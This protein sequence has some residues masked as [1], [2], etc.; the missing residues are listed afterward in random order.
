VGLENITDQRDEQAEH[1]GGAERDAD[2]A[3]VHA[4]AEITGQLAKTK[5]AQEGGEPADQEEG[6][7]GDEKPTHELG[8]LNTMKIIAASARIHWSRGQFGLKK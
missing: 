4:E 7:E 5:A 2:V 3:P 1:D 6:E 8:C